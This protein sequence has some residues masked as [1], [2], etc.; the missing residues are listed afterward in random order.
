MLSTS[1][2]SC[3]ETLIEEPVTNRL[4]VLWFRDLLKSRK[5]ASLICLHIIGN[6][7]TD[8]EVMLQLCTLTSVK[9]L[10]NLATKNLK[11]KLIS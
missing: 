7:T 11:T 4:V 10:R 1:T 2:Y 9:K 3:A 8:F 5:N 6:G